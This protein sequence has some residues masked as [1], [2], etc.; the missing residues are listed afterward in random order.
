MGFLDLNGSD[1][2]PIVRERFLEQ[3]R[4]VSDPR[5][6]VLINNCRLDLTLVRRP[7]DY[8]RRRIS[9]ECTFWRWI[10]LWY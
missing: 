6:V 5:R 1:S 7:L 4:H 2:V 10:S 3:S 8:D 9:E